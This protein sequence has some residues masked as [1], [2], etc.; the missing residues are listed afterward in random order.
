M[1]GSGA[2]RRYAAY[3]LVMDR[4]TLGHLLRPLEARGLVAIGTSDADRRSRAI[5][6]SEEGRRLLLRARRLWRAAQRRFETTFGTEEALGLRRV[7]KQVAT[8][9]I[10]GGEDAG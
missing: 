8:L 5:A 10:G 4:S 1:R 2:R 3:V 9:T 6:L 7:L